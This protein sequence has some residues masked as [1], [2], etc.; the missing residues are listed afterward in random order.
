MRS[1]N[2]TSDGATGLWSFQAFINQR[3][4][5]VFESIWIPYASPQLN[6]KAL[7]SNGATILSAYKFLY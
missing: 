2:K 7:I 3:T 6:F 4:F 1:F 5:A